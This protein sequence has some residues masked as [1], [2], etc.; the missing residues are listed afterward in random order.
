MASRMFLSRSLA[1]LG[2][3]REVGVGGDRRKCK[4]ALEKGAFG[5]INP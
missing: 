4:E 5:I 2:M 1:R 3:F